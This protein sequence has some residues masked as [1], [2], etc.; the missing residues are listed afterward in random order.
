[1][2]APDP[3]AVL[4]LPAGPGLSDEQVRAAWRAI[5]T[6]THPD[7]ADGGDPARYAAASAA[8]A[9]LRTAWGRSEACA[10][11]AAQA[12]P[13]AAASRSAVP[14]PARWLA[15]PV[16]LAPARIWH[17]RPWR[18]VLRVLAAVLLA[19]VAARAGVGG[20]AAAGV[21]A[22]LGIWLVLTARGDLAPPP[23]R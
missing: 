7:R 23:G 5:A 20:P 6:A 15:R 13:L 9:V 17:G 21:V 8:Y 16:A 11:L 19:V 22:G 12:P 1:V 14:V 2:T 4:G 18:L 3:F 10:D